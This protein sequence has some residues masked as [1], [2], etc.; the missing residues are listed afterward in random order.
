MAGGGGAARG[1]PAE[2][3]ARARQGR[4]YGEPVPRLRALEAPALLR[5][6]RAGSRRPRAPPAAATKRLGDAAATARI[7]YAARDSIGVDGAPAIMRGA[8]PAGRLHLAPARPRPAVSRL[9]PP[10][11]SIDVPARHPP[12]RRPC[13]AG[14]G[15]PRPRL[16]PLGAGMP[17][18]GRA[19][20]RNAA[21][22]ALGRPAGQPPTAG[23]R[24]GSG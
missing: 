16:A 13:A 12:R 24:P 2:K 6:C 5:Q 19:A 15:R 20:S 4:P 17:R 10:C 21:S 9:P 7:F 23:R 14:K 1:H 11:H 22:A 18:G 3:A 8:R